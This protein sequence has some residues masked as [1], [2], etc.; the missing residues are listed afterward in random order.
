MIS[1]AIKGP[2]L[3]FWEFFALFTLYFSHISYFNPALYQISLW[4]LAPISFLLC[5]LYTN[6]IAN[7]KYLRI[8]FILFCWC[9]FTAPLALDFNIASAE[10]RR[11]WGVFIY[12]YIMAAISKNEKT[13]LWG[14]GAYIIL[15]I[16]CFIY[17]H[18]NILETMV[19]SNSRLNDEALNANFFGYQFVS[20]TFTIFLY[21]E[22]LKGNIGFFF[23]ILFFVLIPLS[24]YIAILT[25]SRQILLLQI[26]YF[27]Y[28]I[29][30]RY[31][32]GK[33][34]VLYFIIIIAAVIFAY[35]KWG[36]DY[37][38]N[39]YLKTRAETNIG[40][41][42]RSRLLKIAVK[43]GMEH[44]FWGVGPGCFRFSNLEENPEKGFSHCS[45]TELFANNGL[46]AIGLYLYLLFLFLLNSYR[47][48]KHKIKGA[49]MFLIYGIIYFVDNFLYVFYLDPTLLSFFIG[50]A[51]Y[52]KGYFNSTKILL[53]EKNNVSFWHSSGGNQNG[54]TCK[55]VPK[56]F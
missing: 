42:S 17:A 9:S 41:D 39:S 8:V 28:L 34:N 48:T 1:L 40:E 44:P 52:S 12:C 43:T 33:G 16:N 7:D 21:G 25:A 14:F 38:E 4:I 32:I 37:Y 10:I 35:F 22:K 36:E 53:H 50:V 3:K 6:S 47:A 31:L 30:K 5:F 26:P 55:G 13:A 19:A 54:A 49:Y 45:Y 56:T 15:L 18:N 51:S 27:A 29:Y 2:K 23:R 24:F 46:I 20:V 11:I